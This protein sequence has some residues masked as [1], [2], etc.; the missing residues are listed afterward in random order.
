MSKRSLA[1][2]E[3]TLSQKLAR[4]DEQ[5]IIKTISKSMSSILRS[6]ENLKFRE[7]CILAIRKGQQRV[8][9]ENKMDVNPAGSSNHE[10][11]E[12]QIENMLKA[13]ISSK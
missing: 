1:K 7:T 5:K 3:Y 4:K 9:K 11:L 12:M 6:T 2:E 13:N 10:T 8:L